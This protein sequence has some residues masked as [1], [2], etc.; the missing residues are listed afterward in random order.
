MKLVWKNGGVRQIE[1]EGDCPVETSTEDYTNWISITVAEGLVGQGI[2]KMP[3]LDLQQCSEQKL[4]EMRW[5]TCLRVRNIVTPKL[6]GVW[7][8]HPQEEECRWAWSERGIR[9]DIQS[10]AEKASQKGDGEDNEGM[11]C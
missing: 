6:R 8:L 1:I 10:S 9:K 7:D 11:H 3:T 5:M 4:R 2:S